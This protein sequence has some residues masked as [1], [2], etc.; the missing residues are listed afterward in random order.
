[1]KKI[2]LGFVIG[3][4]LSFSVNVSA[5]NEIMAQ[6]ASFK[7]TVNGVDRQVEN[8][9][10][11]VN[12]RSYLPVRE[13]ANLLGYD[14]DYIEATRNIVLT[15]PT[16]IPVTAPQPSQPI[17]LDVNSAIIDAADK[18]K[19]SVVGVV[20]MQPASRFSTQLVEMGSGS[21]VI[22]KVENGIAY[23]ITNHHVIEGAQ[24]I[25]ITL[26]NGNRI[27]AILV[28]SDELTDLALIRVTASELQ[29]T[30]IATLGNSSTLRQG[31]PAIAIGNPL[32]QR[33]AQ[34]V[35]VGVI[36]G[37]N[38][39]LPITIG[40]SIVFEI[41][42]LQTDAAINFGNSGGA[43]VDVRGNLIGINSAKIAQSGVEGIG[44]AIP[45]TNALPIL[46][47]LLEHGRVI[48]PYMGVVTRDVQSLLPEQRVG[49]PV[50]RGVLLTENPVGPALQAGLRLNDIIVEID[51]ARI[52]SIL[53]L[54]RVLFQKRVGDDVKVT[55]YRGQQRMEATVKLGALPS[56]Q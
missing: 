21:G 51:S 29:G 42:V 11:V 26:P 47:D 15:A 19:N 36:S 38:R 17:F 44:F 8:Q 25:N 18:A 45:I 35:T 50:N 4:I 34:T 46:N 16:M 14:V 53:D 28:G 22:Y 27:R 32:G 6:F 24:Q 2:V 10:I 56:P 52:D 13:I 55:F 39:L 33:F 40:G 41:E 54:R 49:L 43:L 9:P 3:A 23:I 1:M 48:R 31:E 37:T 7:F 30:T 20:N 12:G 5:T